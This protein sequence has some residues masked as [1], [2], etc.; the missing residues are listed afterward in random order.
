MGENNITLWFAAESMLIER[1]EPGLRS[2]HHGLFI[3]LASVS[4]MYK[5]ESLVTVKTGVSFD[6]GMIFFIITFL[7]KKKKIQCVSLVSAI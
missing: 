5:H 1:K 3:L 2:L 7:K 4:Q 6:L